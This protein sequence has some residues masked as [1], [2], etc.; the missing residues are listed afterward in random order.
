MGHKECEVGHGFPPADSLFCSLKDGNSLSSQDIFLVFMVEKPQLFPRLPWSMVAAP[1]PPTTAGFSMC[2][3]AV[4]EDH[5][6]MHSL[7]CTA[8]SFICRRG[9]QSLCHFWPQGSGGQG[10][11]GD[12]VCRGQEEG[13]TAVPC[14]V[15]NFYRAICQELF[16][17]IL[18]YFSG[19]SPSPLSLRNA[20]KCR[21]KAPCK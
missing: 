16:K 19:L 2:F 12:K 14:L 10:T 20:D 9:E 6:V 17:S 21:E 8:Q 4:L 1:F 18:F 13:C 5:S 15:T 11:V 7:L 3:P